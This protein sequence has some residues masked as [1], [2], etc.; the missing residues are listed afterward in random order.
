[1]IGYRIIGNTQL[2]GS[3]DISSSKNSALPIIAATILLENQTRLVNLPALSDVQTMTDI[4]RSL[5]GR[6]QT[7]GNTIEISTN[8][9]E[10]KIPPVN[11]MNSI[12][13]SFLLMGPMLARFKEAAIPLPGGC[14]IGARPVDLH[15]QGLV[16]LGADIDIVGCIAY[17]KGKLVGNKVM[18][19]F[20]SVGAT[21]NIIMA[22]VLAKGESCI[23]NAAQEPEIV[24]LCNFL[25]AAGAKISGEGTPNIVVQGVDS[26]KGVKYKPI[27]DR[28]EAGTFMIAAAATNSN[29]KINNINP[30]H[31]QAVIRKLV[32]GGIDIKLGDD[33]IQ[34]YASKFTSS[35][36]YTQPYPGFPTDLQAPMMVLCCVGEERSSIAETM[37][38]NRYIHINQLKKLGADIVISNDK[39]YIIPSKLKGTQV[40]ATD[41][42]GGAAMVI[43]GL[44]AQGIT[45]VEDSGHIKRGYD[46]FAV[47]LN[48]L[49]AD[50]K[51]VTI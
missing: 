35:N 4:L 7:Y 5:G 48:S 32:E 46:S 30:L 17:A 47:K 33:Y 13:A 50:I 28:I 20:P 3:V 25:Q 29:V 18:L 27:S 51:L 24:D 36:I 6:C 42:R 8:N 16:A 45:F 1:M 19:D 34:V 9:L 11:L 43:A 15:L 38:E 31:N 44:C 39:A 26:L 2:N 40:Q 23:K 21:E 10:N 22:T 41:L 12:R 37:F 14:Q 49:G